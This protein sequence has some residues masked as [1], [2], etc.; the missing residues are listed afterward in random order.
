MPK[1]RVAGTLTAEVMR[2][3]YDTMHAYEESA[4]RELE[5]MQERHRRRLRVRL[6]DLDLCSRKWEPCR[7]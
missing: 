3:I 2:A 1:R 7:R 4:A 6:S 5:R